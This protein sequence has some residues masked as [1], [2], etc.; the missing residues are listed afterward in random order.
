MAAGSAQLLFCE[1]IVTV[2]LFLVHGVKETY[3]MSVGD[4]LQFHPALL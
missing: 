2:L 4:Y 3:E 1:A